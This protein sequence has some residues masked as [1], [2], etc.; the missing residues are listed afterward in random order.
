M[1]G[2]FGA[3][4]AR[5][6][7]GEGLGLGLVREDDVH[8]VFHEV[9]EEGVIGFHDIVGGHVDG[10]DAAGGLGEPDGLGDEL[11]V[12][13]EV[14]F[15]VEVV[16]ALEHLGDQVVRTHLE[17]SAHVVGEGTL[18]VGPGDEDHAAAAGLGAVEHLRADAV[19]FHRALEEVPQVVVADLADVARRHPE[20]G[21]AGHGVRGRTARHVLD[22]VFLQRVPDPVARLHVHV[23]HAPK[24]EVEPPEERV[25]RKDGQDVGEGVSDAQDGFHTKAV[26]SNNRQI[27]TLFGDFPLTL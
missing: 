8:V 2:D 10:D 6:Q 12:L 26:F 1:A 9:V 18:G 16:V 7:L 19:L 15:D 27:Y 4:L 11:L 17:G 22:P 13:D 14:A 20:D 21:G 3:G 5:L 24:R 25:V 23:L